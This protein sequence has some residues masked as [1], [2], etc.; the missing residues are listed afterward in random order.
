MAAMLSAAS[1]AETAWLRLDTPN[2]TI[3]GRVGDGKLG[4][5]AIEF[6][7]FRDALAQLLDTRATST[8][9][10]TV[11]IVFE[12]A[13]AFGPFQ[14]VYRGKR[15]DAAGLFV[16][17]EDVNYIAL[18]GDRIE[19]QLIF[20]EYAHLV[21]ANTAPRL[22]RWLGEGLAEYYST[23]ELVDG[24]R[25]ALIGRQIDSHL[26]LLRDAAPLKLAEF[27]SVQYDSPL[28]NEGTRRTVFYAQSWALVHYL[29]HGSPSRSDLVVKYAD[30]VEAGMT[31]AEAW[32][33][34]FGPES[35]ETGLASYIRRSQFR[36]AS[37]TMDGRVVAAAAASTPLPDTDVEAFLGDL[38]SRQE[39]QGEAAARLE[40]VAERPEGTRARTVLAHVRNKQSR[41]S[42]ARALLARTSAAAAGDW[43]A[44]YAF[45]MAAAETFR[46]E[47]PEG[48]AAA[49]TAAAREALLRTL[50]VRPNLAHAWHILG[51][52]ARL[53]DADLDT[54]L[55]AG[56]HAHKLAPKRVEYSLGYAETLLRRR[57]YAKARDVL[58]PLLVDRRAAAL[59]DE[60]RSMLGESATQERAA[61][62]A[63]D[64]EA[65]GSGTSRV[66]LGLRQP[67]PGEE[68]AA[69]ML[70][71]IDCTRDGM[72]LHVRIGGQPI[73]FRASQF[74]NVK[75]SSYRDD[76]R[77]DLA[78]GSRDPENLVYVTWKA[79]AATAGATSPRTLVALEFLPNDYRLKLPVR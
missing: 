42:D 51:A 39:R 45:G 10:P 14:P 41:F 47:T 8:A 11:V 67:Q 34:I 53:A 18:A 35:I 76:L 66:V 7:R 4:S 6:E 75:F 77:G 74:Q 79:A 70:M 54:A 50:A 59:H 72:I 38:L 25:K 71:Q 78:C 43:L 21:M 29:L 68:R 12:S 46:S 9:V 40:P 32:S 1:G 55:R 73:Q 16:P 44:D 22:P 31:P 58:G 15:V 27:L 52:L 61:D 5:V 57:E 19:F 36:T 13:R 17:S 2:F 33:R 65:P 63:P 3:I 49:A 69:G 20:H 60:I 64:V 26:V 37:V 23:F 56:E 28:Y 24:G 30:A 62:E 48:G